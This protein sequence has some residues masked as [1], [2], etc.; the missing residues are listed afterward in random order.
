MSTYITGG[1]VRYVFFLCHFF[2]FEGLWF[3]LTSPSVRAI[4]TR[5]R[6][7]N[8]I[9]IDIF[10]C[11]EGEKKAE[12]G[13]GGVPFMTT[14]ARGG[15]LCLRHSFRP[16][17]VEAAP[18]ATA[19]CC[20]SVCLSYFLFTEAVLFFVTVYVS[21]RCNAVQYSYGFSMPRAL[22][23][24][25]YVLAAAATAAGDV[26]A[27]QRSLKLLDENNQGRNKGVRV[28]IIHTR[29]A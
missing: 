14:S 2:M 24:H 27:W 11:C 29:Y 4:E 16:S 3:G 21:S 9:F 23:H 20:C 7:R 1:S 22:S 18:A 12:P 5:V 26:R 19:G 15:V 6:E 13:G 28:G 10:L 8:N 25:C 17:L